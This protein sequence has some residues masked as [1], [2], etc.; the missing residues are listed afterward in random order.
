MLEDRIVREHPG[1]KRLVDVMLRAL[2]P[3]PDA[4]RA[5]AMALKDDVAGAA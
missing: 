2:L 5:V 1:F 3:Y 4:A